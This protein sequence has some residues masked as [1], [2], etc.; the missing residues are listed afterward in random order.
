[1]RVLTVFIYL[2]LDCWAR[3]CFIASFRQSW[4]TRVSPGLEVDGKVKPPKNRYHLKACYVCGIFL[5]WSQ[6]RENLVLVHSNNWGADQ[7][8]DAQSGQRLRNLLFGK[9]CNQACNMWNFIFLLVIVAEQTG[10]S[11]TCCEK[12]EDR[13]SRTEAQFCCSK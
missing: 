2:S 6:S 12:L 11:I 1:M 4:Y 7:P 9:Y 13:F 8:A 5:I 10:L 3:Q